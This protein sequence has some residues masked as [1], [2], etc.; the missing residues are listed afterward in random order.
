MLV[1]KVVTSFESQ[2]KLPNTERDVKKI[3]KR[4]A[5]CEEGNLEAK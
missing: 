5:V 1:L 3:W 4:S 2:M